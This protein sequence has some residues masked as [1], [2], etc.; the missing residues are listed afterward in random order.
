MKDLP[1]A[2]GRGADCLGAGLAGAGDLL[3]NSEPTALSKNPPPEVRLVGVDCLGAGLAGAGDLLANSEPTALS[4]K[5][6][7]VPT[8]SPI[9]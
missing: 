3:A 6:L 1:D 8:C 5:P 7:D 4:K 2:D 9:C